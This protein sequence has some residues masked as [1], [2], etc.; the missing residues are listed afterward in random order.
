MRN[1]PIAAI[2]DI[3][4]IPLAGPATPTALQTSPADEQGLR[5]SPDG[6]Y[7]SF[8]SDESGR[9]EVY[10]SPT[11]GGAKTLVSKTGTSMAR[12]SRQ[13]GELLYLASDLRVVSVQLRT[14]PTLELGTETTLFVL[15]D[16]RWLDFD[17]SPDGKRF[18]AIVAEV[19]GDDQPLTA[20]LNWRNAIRRE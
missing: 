4:T 11:S 10:V 16:L 9:P 19:V 6:R 13:G 15:K 2:F 14:S 5:F 12:W 7:Y 17:V 18:L 1:E 8:I 3:W 20:I